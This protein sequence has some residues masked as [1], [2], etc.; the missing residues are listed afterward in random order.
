[1][2]I[3][4]IKLNPEQ[5]FQWASLFWM[6]IYND[7]RMRLKHPELRKMA[8]EGFA[9]TIK[10]EGIHVDWVAGTSTAGISPGTTLADML[11]VPFAY[12]RDKPK[13]HGLRNQIEGLDADEDFAGKRVLVIE[14]LISTGGSSAAAVHAVRSANG[15]VDYLFSIF[16]Y[17]LEEAVKMFAGRVPFDKSGARLSPP[18]E[19]RSLLSYEQLLAIARETQHITEEQEAMLKEWRADPFRWGGRH[20]FYWLRGRETAELSEAEQRARKRVCIALDVPTVRD[21]LALAEGTA[22]LVGMYKVGKELHSAAC[23]EGVPIVYRIVE[24]GGKVFLDLKF[25]DTPQTVYNAVKAAL[26]PGV[27]IV[28]IHCSA[29]SGEKM[30]KEAIRASHDAAAY[31][32]MPRPKVIGVTVLTSVDDND[33]KAEYSDT[34]FDA[35]VM[36]RAELAKNWGLDGIVCPASKA[37]ELEK[38]FGE[39]LYVTPGI[40]WGGVAGAGQKQLYTPDRAVQDCKSSILVVGSAVTKTD[41]KN[42]RPVAREI[43]K[44]MAPYV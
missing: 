21:A 14:D 35:L 36:K 44:A 3:K 42:K 15:K 32:N 41:N 34:T 40:E 28:N 23:N 18:C 13:E 9:E 17:G 5:P 25:K 33:L 31:H 1:M 10:K 16:N 7:N 8:A 30:V 4:S 19:V 12:I 6:P 24:S 2:N 20:G 11:N 38:R 43:L 37:G 39:W 27:E 22:D 29:D 26:V